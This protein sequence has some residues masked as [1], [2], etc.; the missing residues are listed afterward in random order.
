MLKHLLRRSVGMC[1][2]DTT[3]F[4][5]PYS[6]NLFSKMARVLA[7]AAVLALAFAPA[8]GGAAT[9]AEA[10]ALLEAGD[11]AGAAAVFTSVRDSGAAFERPRAAVEVL[12]A[13]NSARRA[14]TRSVC[15]I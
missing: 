6:I 15:G 9:L 14:K 12:R 10:Q 8:R 11:V 3:H 7:V 4:S 13:W 5:L 1:G 2:C